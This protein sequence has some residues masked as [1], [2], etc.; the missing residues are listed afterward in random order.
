M[1]VTREPM[2]IMQW[3]AVVPVLLT[4][5][6]VLVAFGY[7]V[8]SMVSLQ[9]NQILLSKTMGDGFE[10]V[11]QSFDRVNQLIVNLPLQSKQINDL[12]KRSNDIIAR[13]EQAVV[14]GA[15]ARERLSAQSAMRDADQDKSLA[16]LRQ[17]MMLDHAALE[18]MDRALQGMI[19]TA[20][21]R[22]PLPRR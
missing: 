15:A 10:K 1:T 14:T 16:E 2:T 6:G 12:E 8:Q 22:A 4:V 20:Q 3:A 18:R 9:A 11:N 17:G 21:G 19:E 5:S 13:L 7:L